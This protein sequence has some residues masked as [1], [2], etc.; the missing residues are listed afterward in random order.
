MQNNR[1]KDYFKKLYFAKKVL[2]G[3]KKET[4]KTISGPIFSFTVII[5]G[6]C[7]LARPQMAIDFEVD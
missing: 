4:F 3:V 1:S 2:S 7:G 5:L 6:Y